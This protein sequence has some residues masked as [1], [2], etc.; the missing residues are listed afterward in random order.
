MAAMQTIAADFPTKPI[1]I[2]VPYAAGSGSDSNTR[3]YSDIVSKRWAQTIVVEN[4]PGADGVVAAQMVKSAPV[5][6]YTLM[7]GSSGPMSVNVVT[8]KDLPYQPLKDFRPITLF[9]LGPVAFVS[10]AN[11]PHRTV[12]DHIAAAKRTGAPM[13]VATYSPTYE[14]VTLWLAAASGVGVTVVPYKGLSAVATELV[15]HQVPLGA[16]EPSGALPLIKDGRL[17]VIAISTSERHALLPDTPTLIESG[18]PDMVSHTWSSIV[19]PRGVPS[20]IINK[21]HEGF[22]AAMMTPEGRAY[23]E[24][25]VVVE[26]EHTPDEFEKFIATEIERFRKI[27]QLAG[28]KAK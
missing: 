1:R 12:G 6:G 5:D 9:A 27:A 18:F 2:V 24:G 21:I 3:F 4:R 28:I 13:Q 26:V 16:I 7:V 10:G 23:R 11:S 8:V 15:G 22:R 14:I 19:A 17:R 20:A 25:R